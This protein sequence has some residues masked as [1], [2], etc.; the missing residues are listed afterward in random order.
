MLRGVVLR[1]GAEHLVGSA[2]LSLSKTVTKR[3]WFTS[4]RRSGPG[5]GKDDAVRVEGGDGGAHLPGRWQYAGTA[6]TGP[7]LAVDGRAGRSLEH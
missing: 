1:S 2:T 7:R 3:V 6:G 5:L 4:V